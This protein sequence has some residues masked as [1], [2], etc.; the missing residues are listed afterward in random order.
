M[1]RKRAIVY[2]LVPLTQEFE[3]LVQECERWA[4]RRK[5]VLTKIV[6]EGN[7][8]QPRLL[9]LLSKLRSG[10]GTPD[11][12]IAPSL[13]HFA[14][15]P[16]LWHT[17]ARLHGTGVGIGLV[18]ENILLPGASRATQT[19]YRMGSEFTRAEKCGHREALRKA[20][21]VRAIFG[22]SLGRERLPVA[23]IRDCENLL[24]QGLSLQKVVNELRARGK[25]ISRSS[26]RNVKRRLAM[27]KSGE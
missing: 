15:L 1:K 3:T 24:S 26:V 12:I 7:P 17:L 9:H 19:L 18:A 27:K 13:F 11:Y 5:L 6:G 25:V 22:K 23:L 2:V 20:M 14:R 4:R 8:R 21:R 16:K 10:W